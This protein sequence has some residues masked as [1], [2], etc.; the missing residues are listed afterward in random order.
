MKTSHFLTTNATFLENQ[1]TETKTWVYSK[2]NLKG[3]LYKV[4]KIEFILI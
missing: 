3:T 1:E 2:S 4:L